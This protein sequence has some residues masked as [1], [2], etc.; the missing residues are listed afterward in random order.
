MIN[1][2]SFIGQYIADIT[3]AY[4]FQKELG[5]GAYGKVFKVKNLKTG[6]TYAC[7]K[8]N[9]RQISN[10]DRFKVEIDLLKATDHPFIV[11][12]IDLYEDNI[13]L[14][15]VMEECFGGELFDRLAKR[16]REKNLYT[17]RET[18]QIFTK[19]MTGINYCH[20]HG[21]CH[22][23]IKPENILFADRDDLSTLK[24][25]DFGLSRVFSSEDKIMTSIVGTTFYMSPEV[26]NGSYNEKCDIW[27][28]GCILYIMLCGRPPFYAKNDRDL[29]RK[30][31]SKAYTFNH[32]EFNTVSI[33]AKDLISRM[34]CDEDKRLSAQGVLDHIWVK[35][36]A[37]RSKELLLE[38]KFDNIAEYSHMNALKKGVFSFIAT[39]MS[40]EDVNNLAD[41][42]N[43]LDK[44]RDG[45]LTLKEAKGAIKYLKEEKLKGKQVSKTVEDVASNI[46][47]VFNEMDLDK[48]GLINYSEFIAATMDHKKLLLKDN[49]YEAFRMFD[50][51]QS[52]KFNL[53]NLTD[54]IRPTTQDDL[55][56]LK[57][58]F[59]SFDLDKD[60]FISYDEFMKALDSN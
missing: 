50:S 25:A 49:I 38:L 41:I 53:K 59:D 15:L 36:N 3:K 56:Y 10:K 35:Q 47:F 28:A 48:N 46:E 44:N 55:N 52:G 20:A 33:D 5:S 39:R 21:V 43:T 11:K 2:S 40:N 7:K 32:P 37:P 13:F 18:C 57:K 29:M 27:S 19:L 14:Y 34:L 6:K 23:D 24:I 60:G 17:E 9:K 51:T 30:I 26:L 8:M 1:K 4:E 12:L 31:Q 16:S 42:F 22:R 45:V 58:M 54:I